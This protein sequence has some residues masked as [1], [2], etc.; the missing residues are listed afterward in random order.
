MSREVYVEGFTHF[1]TEY[2]QKGQIRLLFLITDRIWTEN[3]NLG[4]TK[5]IH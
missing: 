3:L 4:R 2:M 5:C 1:F